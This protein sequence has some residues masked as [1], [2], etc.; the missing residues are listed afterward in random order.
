MPSLVGSEMCIRDS[1]Y[2]GYGRKYRQG[3]VSRTIL[4]LSHSPYDLAHSSTCCRHCTASLAWSGRPGLGREAVLQRVSSCAAQPQ[5]SIKEPPAALLLR[6]DVD[7]LGRASS[8]SSESGS[9]ELLLILHATVGA[10]TCGAQP[11]GSHSARARCAMQ[12]PLSR[13]HAH[14]LRPCRRQGG[15]VM[16]RRA[17]PASLPPRKQ[18]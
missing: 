7:R 6:H 4:K 12:P 9:L 1:L 16:R 2:T 18:T 15:G 8:A 5:C 10:T 3:C 14:T 17:G 11:G 13:R